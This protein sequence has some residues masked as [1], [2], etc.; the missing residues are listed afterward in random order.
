MR[1]GVEVQMS[2]RLD[3][4]LDCMAVARHG[5]RAR[6]TVDLQLRNRTID[7]VPESRVLDSRRSRCTPLPTRGHAHGGS[8][9]AQ[10]KSVGDL[11]RR[12]CAG[13]LHQVTKR[14]RVGA[15][16]RARNGTCVRMEG[17]SVTKGNKTMRR[18][19][20]DALI[21]IGA[22]LLLLV[23]LVSIDDRVRERVAGP[24]DNATE[25]L[26]DRRRRRA[27]RERVD[28]DVQGGAR[29]ERRT[30][31][32]GDLRGRR[33]GTGFVHVANVSGYTT[34]H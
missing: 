14:Q 9:N 22:V 34:C 12:I 6:C 27:D 17:R 4:R 3:L 8:V 18:V 33:D 24:G 11:A 13:L 30:R 10:T 25:L 28:P 5:T 7:S 29:S 26:G 16:Q 23:A 31:S 1:S 20:S 19:V 21:S 2:Q 15:I 32:D